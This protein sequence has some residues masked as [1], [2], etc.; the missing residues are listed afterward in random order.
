MTNNFKLSQKMNQII[1]TLVKLLTEFS[2]ALQINI[3]LK[4]KKNL[5]SFNKPKMST[6]YSKQQ[7]DKTQTI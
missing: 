6:F 3:V 2:E 7:I 1:R 4:I 5:S